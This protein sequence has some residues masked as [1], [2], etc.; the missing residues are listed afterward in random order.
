MHAR[1]VRFTDVSA[2]RVEELTTRIQDR[3]APPEDSRAKGV[4]VFFDEEQGTAV[5]LQEFDSAEDLAVGEKVFGG[6]DSGDTPG[7]R[8]TVDRCELKIER[9]I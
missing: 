4:K 6:M 7:T 1:V 8:A 3:D 2:E 9:S 5:V